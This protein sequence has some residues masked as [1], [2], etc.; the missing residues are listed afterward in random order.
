MELQ[1]EQHAYLEQAPEPT[2]QHDTIFRFRPDL[3]WKSGKHTLKS[4]FLLRANTGSNVSEESFL[5]NVEELFYEYRPYPTRWRI[6]AN[7]YNWGIIDGYSPLDVVN[8]RVFLDP[9]GSEKRGATVIDSL[10][11]Q[12]TW[13]VQALYIPIQQKPVL[14]A[15]DSR[16]L[17]R[18][19]VIDN[20]G[21]ETQLIS[22]QSL[23]FNYEEEKELDDA[24]SNN[25]ALQAK[26]RLDF[27]DLG[28]VYFEGLA[29]TP[30]FEI[31]ATGTLIQ[32]DPRIIQINPDVQLT[33]VY[34][35]V[36][37]AGA[38]FVIPVGNSIFRLESAYTDVISEVVGIPEWSHQSVLALESPFY[39]GS[40]SLTAMVQ[41]Y[42]GDSSI[43]KDNL[44]SSS[45]RI[46]DDSVA[47]G[48]RYAHSSQNSLLAFA[49][50]NISSES[51]YARMDWQISFNS[52]VSGS[53]VYE[54]FEG[55]ESTF[56]GTYDNND[57]ARV[58]IKVRY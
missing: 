35:K 18:S 32:T 2:R 22:P 30:Q 50:Y 31:T 56:L 37:V 27:I 17:P 48:F 16:W 39:F 52:W 44:V 33:P 43:G 28:L 19:I 3:S 5:L 58:E 47:L 25:F 57:R 41:G 20:S 36:R 21:E 7:T 4:S 46:F 51:S 40:R 6:G 1:F 11:E 38:Q 8:S 15:T 42:Y 53:V 12:D 34:Y 45:S 10:F 13:S 54:N 55:N 14:P 9:L 49:V 24:F 26:K 29:Q 23:L